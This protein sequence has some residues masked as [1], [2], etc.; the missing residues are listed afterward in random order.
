MIRIG[1]YTFEGNVNFGQKSISIVVPLSTPDEVFAAL[2]TAT[3]LEIVNGDTVDGS[4]RLVD[5]K[6][7]EK[8][9]NGILFTWQT[10]SADEVDTLK[11]QVQT[12]QGDLGVTTAALNV[13]Q[14]NLAN[15]TSAVEDIAHAIEEGDLAEA[16]AILDILLGEESSEVGDAT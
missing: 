1:D 10:V 15:L 4:Y 5:W 13:T 6:G 9:W 3:T 2:K 16:K 7:Q 11:E 14:R 12:L 8:L